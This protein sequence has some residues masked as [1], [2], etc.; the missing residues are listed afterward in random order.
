MS[1]RRVLELFTIE[2][3]CSFKFIRAIKVHAC[4]VKVITRRK[5]NGNETGPIMNGYIVEETSRYWRV[6]LCNNNCIHF[7]RGIHSKLDSK[8]TFTDYT[9]NDRAIIEV[10]PV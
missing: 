8:Y 10:C 6:K 7:C 5:E 3:L 2:Q 9:L 4:C 1:L